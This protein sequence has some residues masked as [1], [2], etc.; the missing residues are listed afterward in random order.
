MFE[1]LDKIMTVLKMARTDSDR[2]KVLNDLSSAVKDEI[3]LLNVNKDGVPYHNLIQQDVVN[4]CVA[5]MN[6]CI[7]DAN[8]S[9]V[10]SLSVEIDVK[11]K[12]S[13][14]TSASFIKHRSLPVGSAL[15]KVDKAISDYI[16]SIAGLD[17]HEKIVRDQ[18]ET[19]KKKIA[20]DNYAER[21]CE[22][23]KTALSGDNYKAIIA[24]YEKI[25]PK[26]EDA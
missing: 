18:Y 14:R 15:N 10:F 7:T 5:Y 8:L 22:P 26:K 12:A 13:V 9:E 16:K 1:E 2:K 4:E 3:Q 6:S 11:G 17:S 23:F 20:E 24:Y 19:I 25:N 21:I